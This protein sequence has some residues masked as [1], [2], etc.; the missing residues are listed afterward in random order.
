MASGRLLFSAKSCQQNNCYLNS[1]Q[2]FCFAFFAESTNQMALREILTLFDV[3][4]YILTL[5]QSSVENE[6]KLAPLYALGRDKRPSLLG[7]MQKNSFCFILTR[8]VPLVLIGNWT[9]ARYKTANVSVNMRIQAFHC[10]NCRMAISQ[11]LTQWNA[12]QVRPQSVLHCLKHFLTG[13]CK[14]NCVCEREQW[15]L[16]HSICGTVSFNTIVIASNNDRKQWRVLT[17]SS[18]HIEKYL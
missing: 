5:C 12:L 14:K 16:C 13:K 8:T 10:A 3:V 9:R 1:V 2:M 15:H 17:R 6:F 7:Q 4:H 11:M 18:H